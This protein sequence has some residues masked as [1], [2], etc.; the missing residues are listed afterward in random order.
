VSGTPPSRR[1]YAS[2]VPIV[3]YRIEPQGERD[4]SVWVR[5]KSRPAIVSI[6]VC[7]AFTFL[8]PALFFFFFFTSHPS[9]TRA[10]SSNGTPICLMPVMVVVVGLALYRGVRGEVAQFKGLGG[11]EQWSFA[12]G[13]IAAPIDVMGYQLP[14]LVAGI[15]GIRACLNI[16]GGKW[17]VDFSAGGRNLYLGPFDSKALAIRC[18]AELRRLRP[19]WF[20]ASSGIAV[21]NGFLGETRFNGVSTPPEPIISF[22]PVLIDGGGCLLEFRRER[23]APRLILGFLAVWLCLWLAGEFMVGWIL[24]GAFTGIPGPGGS[25]ESRSAYL[26]L[27]AFLLLWT[28]FGFG[29]FWILTL[30]LKRKEVWRFTKNAIIAGRSWHSFSKR[31][32]P[33]DQMIQVR[34]GLFAGPPSVDF[35][36]DGLLLHLG[37]FETWELAGEAMG[38]VERQ[39]PHWHWPSMTEKSP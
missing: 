10:Q 35:I 3:D 25:R 16:I 31:R 27:L 23:G 26:F 5:R 6:I 28:F 22:E 15:E 8:F 7:A 18:E 17:V 19:G 39:F 12:H 4:F 13:Q 38:D 9:H 1:P 14:P 29:A 21:L 20:A 24:L 11:K 36:S 33:I 37:P 30:G 2:N 34:F 32:L